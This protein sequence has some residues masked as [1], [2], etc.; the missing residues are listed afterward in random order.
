MAFNVLDKEDKGYVTLD[1]IRN[2]LKATNMYPSEKCLKLF[3]QRLD[4]DEDS[5]IS[6]DEFVTGLSPFQSNQD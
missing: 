1:D 6:Y 4:K 3:Y 2:F 5:V